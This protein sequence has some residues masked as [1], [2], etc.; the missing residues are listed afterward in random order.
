MNESG[1]IWLRKHDACSEAVE[2]AEQYATLAEAF[3]ACEELDW[4]IWAVERIGGQDKALRLFACDCVRDVWHLLTDERSRKAVE[5]AEAF[6]VGDASVEELAG[7]ARDAAAAAWDATAAAAA[8]AWAAWDAAADDA[9]A[10]DAT[11]AAWA[12]AAAADAWDAWA[13]RAAARA[14]WAA[15]AAA[16]KAKQLEHF[17]ARVRNPFRGEVT[18]E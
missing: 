5:V 1:K 14:A 10:A 18:N 8:D 4:L 6:A 3:D 7:A 15:R 11:A 16:T 17:R 2:W 9:W 13:A 12:A